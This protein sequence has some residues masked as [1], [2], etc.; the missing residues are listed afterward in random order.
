MQINKENPQIKKYVILIICLLL[1][2]IHLFI[3]GNRLRKVSSINFLE[4][5]QTIYIGDKL[6][7]Y[8]IIDT[9]YTNS[10]LTSIEQTEKGE[11]N[12]I[13]CQ[14]YNHNLY[15]FKF[16]IHKNSEVP[17][18]FCLKPRKFS[19]NRCVLIV[20]EISEKALTI[21]LKLDEIPESVAGR[22]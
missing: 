19:S 5:E 11:Y 15:E 7:N 20:K 18:F 3:L 8:R 14:E 13:F 16:N 22:E 1:V 21:K 17:A 4:R 2:V 12:V 10:F 6:D 9:F